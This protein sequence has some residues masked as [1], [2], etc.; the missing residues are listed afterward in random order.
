MRLLRPLSWA[1]DRGHLVQ[2]SPSKAS[3]NVSV[4]IDRTGVAL[5]LACGVH[6]ALVPLVI[7]AAA[8]LP[9]KWLVSEQTELWLLAGSVAIALSSLLSGYW[10]KHHSKRCL[11]F[12]VPG[13]AVFGLVL[14]GSIN[15][16]LEPWV[17]VG[18]ASLIAVGHLVNIRLCRQC[19]Q[20][21]SAAP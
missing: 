5:S 2:H 12:F 13:L 19:V 6:C 20:C 18:G 21:Q 1:T 15:E 8:L 9:A 4:W 17:V 10:L 14:F 11:A 3:A 16:Q 7:G